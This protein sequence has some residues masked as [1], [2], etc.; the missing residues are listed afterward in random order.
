MRFQDLEALIE[1]ARLGSISKASEMLHISHTALGKQIRSL[2]A[3]YGVQLLKRTSSGVT[4]TEAG[5][6]L[7]NRVTDLLAEFESIRNELRVYREPAKYVI[8]SLPSLAASYLPD[9]V[10]AMKLSGTDCQVRIMQTSDELW[11]SLKLGS[12]DGILAEMAPENHLF[13]TKVLFEEPFV[14]VVHKEHPFT[15]FQSVQP[16]DLDGQQLIL[17]PSG[18]GIR[19]WVINAMRQHG[20][21]P[22]ITN[23]VGFGGFIAGMVAAKAG[24]TVLPESTAKRL[25][26]PDLITVPFS[27]PDAHRTIVF[28]TANQE[29]GKRLGPYF[30]TLIQVG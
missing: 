10:L 17:Y 27:S 29:F 22:T 3:F 25:G 21:E 9:R 7:I 1:A 12:L 16:L 26:E 11:E 4:P 15:K 28:A 30:K 5:M 6:H 24:I 18:C 23:E 8:G 2:E 19:R 14:T 20:C 13:F